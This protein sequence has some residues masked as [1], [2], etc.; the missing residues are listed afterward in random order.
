MPASSTDKITE[1]VLAEFDLA[2]GAKLIGYQGYCAGRWQT[3]AWMSSGLVTS[4]GS[5]ASL[6]EHDVNIRASSNL[7]VR[8]NQAVMLL[9]R[10]D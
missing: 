8:R 1:T 6:R 5:A 9:A 3:A 4:R 7:G 10:A 2:H